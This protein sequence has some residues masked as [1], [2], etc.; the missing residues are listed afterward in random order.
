MPDN[1][2]TDAVIPNLEKEIVW[3]T[4]QIGALE[5]AR[6]VGKKLRSIPCILNESAKLVVEILGQFLP[7]DILVIPHNGVYL[8]KD[9]AMK[10][11]S[12]RGDR[13]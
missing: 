13:A 8:R 10:D 11:D 5:A 12:H 9:P 2:N 6:A 7:R 1:Q 3:E 4:L